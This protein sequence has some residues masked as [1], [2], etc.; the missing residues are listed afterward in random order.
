M[1]Y[2]TP[3][4]EE[5]AEE[6]IARFQRV[7]SE[8]PAPGAG[9]NPALLPVAHAAIQCGMTRTEFADAVTRAVKPGT[10]GIAP[11]ELERAY[12]RAAAGGKG[13]HEPKVRVVV[14]ALKRARVVAAGK[15]NGRWWEPIP[16]LSPG[17]QMA[18]QL[19]S[20]FLPEDKVWLGTAEKDRPVYGTI[21]PAMEWARRARLGYVQK[22]YVHLILNPLGREGVTKDGKPSTTSD[23]NVMRCDNALLEFD[24]L[25]M[26]EQLDFWAGIEEP[27][28]RCLTYSGG[29][30]VHAV[31]YVGDMVWSEAVSLF[32]DRIYG[33]L[34]IDR[35]VFT[36]C[37]R[38][39]LAGAVR[40]GVLQQLM[41]SK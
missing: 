32:R 22:T 11:N 23:A 30:S 27:R 6:T 2:L 10:R 25:P 39:R 16:L 12:D 17:E 9:F 1:N 31:L 21:L 7:L 18:R 14:D 3:E 13:N 26:E 41:W 29:K 8:L 20:L 38:A 4:L 19:E 35:A 15:E 36:P 5:L 33:P 40:N 34:G 24:G 37:R 28:L